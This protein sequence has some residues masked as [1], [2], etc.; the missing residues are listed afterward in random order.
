MLCCSFAL[1]IN[2]VWVPTQSTWKTRRQVTA[3]AT[4]PLRPAVGWGCAA[5]LRE[6]HQHQQSEQVGAFQCLWKLLNA[7]ISEGS[8]DRAPLRTHV[9]TVQNVCHRARPVQAN[10]TATQSRK[11]KKR[12][13]EESWQVACLKISF[14]TQR[15]YSEFSDTCTKTI[16][17]LAIALISTRCTSGH[18]MD[19]PDPSPNNAV[20]KNMCRFT[21]FYKNKEQLRRDRFVLMWCFVWNMTIL[22][23]VDGIFN[24]HSLV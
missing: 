6:A 16:T 7:V 4:E 17:L 18:N 10:T 12:K 14:T 5:Y 13:L 21:T 8:D 9:Q 22:P 23:V 3:R 20:Q 1:S 11:E 2:T 24:S 15:I 19:V